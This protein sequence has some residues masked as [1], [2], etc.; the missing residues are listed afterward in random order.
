F[1][2][3]L[4]AIYINIAEGKIKAPGILIQNL[5]QCRYVVVSKRVKD[6]YGF[7]EFVLNADHDPNMIKVYEDIYSLVYQIIER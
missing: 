1:D 3:K 5:F 6:Y 4:S 2:E 7:E